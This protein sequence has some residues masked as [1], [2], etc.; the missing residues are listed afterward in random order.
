MTLNVKNI[1][2]RLNKDLNADLNENY[3][4]LEAT[5]TESMNA[6]LEKKIVKF[7]GKKHKKDPWITYGILKSVIHKNELYKIL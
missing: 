6:H 4:M 5:I 3:A 7:N 2:E 1:Y